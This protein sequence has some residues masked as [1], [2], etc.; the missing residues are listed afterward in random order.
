MLVKKLLPL[1]AVAIMAAA[2]ISHAAE[3]STVKVDYSKVGWIPP[4]SSSPWKEWQFDPKAAGRSWKLVEELNSQ[5]QQYWQIDPRW[6]HE[7]PRDS[8][9][10]Y[11]PQERYPFKAPWSGEKLAADYDMYYQ[12]GMCSYIAH[13]GYHLQRTVDRNGVVSKGDQLCRTAKR[14]YKTFAQYLYDIKPGELHAF[15]LVTLLEPPESA[16]TSVLSKFY[17]TTPDSTRAEDRWIYV[18]SLRRIRRFSGASGA[19]YVAGSPNTYDDFFTRKFWQYDSK[20]IGVD[21]LYGA[22]G[23]AKPYGDIDGPY[24]K[25]G[26]I[27]AYVVLNVPK[28]SSYYLKQWITWHDK[29]SHHV[30]RIEQWDKNGNIKLVGEYGLAGRVEYYGKLEYPWNIAVQGGLSDDGTERR[31]ILMGG[32]PSLAWDADTDL[33]TYTI[34]DTPETGIPYE[35]FGSLDIFPENWNSYFSPNRLEQPFRYQR[36]KLQIADKDIPG[37]PILYREKFPTFRKIVLPGELE[38]KIKQD[39]SNQR[40]L[41]SLAK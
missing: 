13:N 38:Q 7:I 28:D 27:E 15:Y 5:E 31:G 14:N 37:R 24:R 32:G 17:K 21:I 10:P 18:P 26:G 4:A 25:D 12:S 20:V 40:G 33:R 34:P 29:K 6:G 39:E 9:Y 23:S 36:S 41:F 30:I 35:K 2:G 22:A 1:A 11:L 8:E 19:D 3:E 16:G